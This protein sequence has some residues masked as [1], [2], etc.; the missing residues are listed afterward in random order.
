MERGGDAR[1]G[2]HDWVATKVYELPRRLY[3]ERHAREE[4]RGV[5]AQ[6]DSHGR[7]RRDGERLGGLR[8]DEKRGGEAQEE[9]LALREGRG[10]SD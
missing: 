5:H 7:A 3:R 8:E 4:A 6:R 1:E 10:V 2:I 9:V